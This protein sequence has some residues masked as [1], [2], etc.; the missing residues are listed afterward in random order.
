VCLTA[1]ALRCSIWIAL[2]QAWVA[3]AKVSAHD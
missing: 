1:I 3:L 2:E